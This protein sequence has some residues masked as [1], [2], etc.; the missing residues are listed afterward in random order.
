MKK[1]KGTPKDTGL[2]RRAEER[3]KGKKKEAAPPPAEQ[4]AR[5]MVH[6]LEVHRIELEMQNE[7]LKQARGELERQV[8][9]YSDLYNFAPVG[10]FT[11]DNAGTIREANLSGA[12]LLGIERSRLK[13]RRL[14]SFLRAE[15]RER[16][17]RVPQRDIRG[18]SRAELRVGAPRT[19]G[20]AQVRT[21]RG[22]AR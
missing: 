2:R 8:E 16:L 19:R 11:L 6:E 15:S 18:D 12:R 10:Y 4:D 21:D 9:K 22:D 20:R 5:R 7:E 14:G 1:E 3:L 17:R 13:G